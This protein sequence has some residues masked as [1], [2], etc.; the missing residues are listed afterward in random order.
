M[1]LIYLINEAGEAIISLLVILIIAALACIL[2]YT[3]NK[4]AYK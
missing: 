3:W 1:E 4:R 2:Y